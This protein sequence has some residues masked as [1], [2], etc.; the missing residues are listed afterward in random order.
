M[1]SW[2]L[3]FYIA[4][5]ILFWTNVSSDA[6]LWARVVTCTVSQTVRQEKLMNPTRKHSN[7]TQK[8]EERKHSNFTPT[9]QSNQSSISFLVRCSKSCINLG[10]TLVH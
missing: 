8:K 7:F 2:H 10:T 6:P 3:Q 9:R 1:F 4:E 5:F